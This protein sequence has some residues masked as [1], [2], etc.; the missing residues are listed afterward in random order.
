MARFVTACV[1]LVLVLFAHGAR[2][3]EREVVLVRITHAPLDAVV[4]RIRGQVSDLP[5]D[6]RSVEL[7]L[8]DARAPE[9][10]LQRGRDDSALAV[11]WLEPLSDGT[12]VVHVAASRTGEVLDRRLEPPAQPPSAALSE[13]L[14]TAAVV[15]RA[16]LEALLAT[17]RISSSPPAVE[18]P[19]PI[20]VPHPPATTPIPPKQLAAP[21]PP[22]ARDRVRFRM[23][24]G[25][26]VVVDGKTNA[27]LQGPV[28]RGEL[29]WKNVGI[30]LQ[31]AVSLT[32]TIDDTTAT[33][34]VMRGSFGGDL[35][36]AFP[37]HRAWTL[38]GHLGGGI[39]AFNRAT[40]ENP[41]AGVLSTPDQ[42]A[43]TAE[44]GADAVV[45]FAPS[46]RLRSL[47]LVGSAGAGLLFARPRYD[48]VTTQGIVRGPALW[49][50]QPRFMLGLAWQF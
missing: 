8:L 3:S 38:E 36:A 7:E 13:R 47:R 22:P 33:L 11:V 34:H 43:W 41:A 35:L 2:A 48:F 26:L 30:G 29:R 5:I 28:V 17:G 44:L 21:P 49:P 46:Q 10:A 12:I 37:L 18:V 16:T 23:G 1:L 9:T 4:E 40:V 39:V 14:E 24:L 45:A 42:T 27:G 6:V 31:G 15:V 19:V 20:V 25:W 32:G 50:V